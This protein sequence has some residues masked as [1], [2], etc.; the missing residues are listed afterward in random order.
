MSILQ[1]GIKVKKITLSTT[2]VYVPTTQYIKLIVCS[3]DSD[4]ETP[5]S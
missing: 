1:T 2:C 4:F 5:K 3:I